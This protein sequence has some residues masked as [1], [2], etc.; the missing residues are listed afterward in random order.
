MELREIH[1]VLAIAKHQS[2]TRAAESLYLSQPTLSKFLIGLEQELGVKLFRRVGNRYVLTYAGERY[3]AHAIRMQ[4]LNE[5]LERELADIRA[6]GVGVLHLAV[7]PSCSAF[8]L[9]GV[10]PQLK[11]LHPQL[12]VE[13]LEGCKAEILQSV[14]D[15]D[16]ELGVC[17]LPLEQNPQLHR[18][19]IGRETLLACVRPGHSLGS[20][21]QTDPEGRPCLDPT[22]IEAEQL[23][24]AASSREQ[25]DRLLRSLGLSGSQALVLGSRESV[26]ALASD[27]FGVGLLPDSYLQELQSR[28]KALPVAVY[29]LRGGPAVT[30][31]AALTRKGSYLPVCAAD[32]IELMRKR[33]L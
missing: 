5:S 7:E 10:L 2:I 11:T 1:Y 28:Q 33:Y 22:G 23:L 31:Y 29:A 13:V 4:Q 9:P 30:E 6:K 20:L 19:A 21:A 18:E 24:L 12:R 17:S 8:L 3:A 14:L 25:A 27:G 15:G 32:C 16:A 26:L